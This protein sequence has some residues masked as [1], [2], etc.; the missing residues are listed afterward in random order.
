MLSSTSLCFAT[1]TVP[2]K[3]SKVTVDYGQGRKAIFTLNMPGLAHGERRYQIPKVIGVEFVFANGKTAKVSK[4]GLAGV[5]LQG[6]HSTMIET[7]VEKGSWFLTMRIKNTEV[8][9]NRIANDWVVFIFDS[10]K[11]EKR[12]LER[13]SK[14][15]AE[16]AKAEQ[17]VARQSATRLESKFHR[18]LQPSTRV[19]A[20]LP[21]ADVWTLMFC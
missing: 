19:E 17:D 15:N 13:N 8:I 3:A 1:S 14:R 16:I 21:V 5:D 2:F 6:I 9:E 12:W 4:E 10:Y 7:G 11:Y 18:E 20:S